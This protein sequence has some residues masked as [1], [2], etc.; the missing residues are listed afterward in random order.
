MADCFPGQSL[1]LSQ[2][3]CSCVLCSSPAAGIC[4]ALLS[5][6]GSQQ[7]GKPISIHCEKA[8]LLP[9][10]CPAVPTGAMHSCTPP[11]PWFDPQ[12]VSSTDASSLGF[13]P[14]LGSDIA[15]SLGC[16]FCSCFL[17]PKLCKTYGILQLKAWH[18]P[19]VH[20]S[21]LGESPYR[22]ESSLNSQCSL[23]RTEPALPLLRSGLE[24]PVPPGETE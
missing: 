2:P 11:F 9:D 6:N 20:V 5:D 23:S 13:A 17:T 1:F 7:R 16:G 14:C 3:C 8:Q 21:L 12:R 18:W 15:R 4:S 19:W 24:L 22:M 10:V